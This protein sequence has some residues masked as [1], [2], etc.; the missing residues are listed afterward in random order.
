MLK[1]SR[2]KRKLARDIKD[3]TKKI[4]IVMDLQKRSS[5]AKSMLLRDREVLIDQ[6]TKIIDNEEKELPSKNK[7]ISKT[8]KSE[9]KIKYLKWGN[10][11]WLKV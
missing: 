2:N 1:I 10:I 11:K 3:H 7:N 9:K 4:K 5:I 6:L 8:N